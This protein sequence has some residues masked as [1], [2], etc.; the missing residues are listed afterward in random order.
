MYYLDAMYM[1]TRNNLR[2]TVEEH[3]LNLREY[4]VL[5]G[6]FYLNMFYQPPQPQGIVS[7]D[8]SISRCKLHFL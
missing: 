5:G 4:I 2:T 6:I 3:V 1:E 7:Y 8:M